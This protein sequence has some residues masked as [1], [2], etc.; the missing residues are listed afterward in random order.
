MSSTVQFLYNTFFKTLVLVFLLHLSCGKSYAVEE[1]QALE[2]SEYELKAAYIYNF[3]KFTNFKNKSS[4]KGY[5]VCVFVDAS[6]YEDFFGLEGKVL[7][8]R[9]LKV[10][11]KS[12]EDSFKECH[13]LFV[14]AD[15]SEE[16]VKL[17]KKSLEENFILVDESEESCSLG[18][19]ISF[20]QDNKRLKFRVN[21]ESIENR[22]F[23]LSAQLLRVASFC[24]KKR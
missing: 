4:K 22:D 21:R 24:E 13:V 17:S 11:L 6:V 7:N 15:S 10:F 14:P 3:L 8:K 12:S 1:A 5:K 16:I 23:T 18:G 2:A 20:F 19:I 9:K